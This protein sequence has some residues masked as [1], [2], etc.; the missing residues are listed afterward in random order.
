MVQVGGCGCSCA[1]CACSVTTRPPASSNNVPCAPFS[2]RGADGEAKRAPPAAPPPAAPQ[3]RLRVLAFLFFV[4]S[5]VIYFFVHINTC[6]SFIQSW[7][8]FLSSQVRRV[9]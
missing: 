6:S 8:G 5:S 4:L 1:L 9:C 7:L 2:C 3:V